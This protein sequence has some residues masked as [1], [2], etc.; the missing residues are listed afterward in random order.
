[1]SNIKNVFTSKYEI[2]DDEDIWTKRKFEYELFNF[3]ANFKIL[4]DNNGI[5]AETYPYYDQANELMYQIPVFKPAPVFEINRKD[6]S[7]EIRE[8]VNYFAKNCYPHEFDEM[9]VNA[10][11]KLFENLNPRYYHE[12]VRKLLVVRFD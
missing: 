1:L 4:L 11:G 6:L 10:V 8:K 5:T 7:K 3:L 12:S 2:T 9:L